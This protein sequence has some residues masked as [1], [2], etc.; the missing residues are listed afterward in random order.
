MELASRDIS[1]A[2][3]WS[4]LKFVGVVALPPALWAFVM[5][6]TG[7][8]RMFRRVLWFL[9]IEPAIVLGTL[10]VPAT[11]HLLHY[12]PP[13]GEL[14][15][16]GGSPIPIAGPLFWPHA[17]YTYALMLGATAALSVSLV[18]G[19]AVPAAGDRHDHRIRASVPRQRRLQPRRAGHH[20]RPHPV[21]VHADRGRPR[22]GAAAA[23]AARPDA[24][25]PRRGGGAD[26]RGRARP[27]RLR[28]DRGRQPRRRQAARPAASA[29]GRTAARG[30]PAVAGGANPPAPA[31]DAD[32]QRVP[33]PHRDAGLDGETDLAVS[34]TG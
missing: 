23:A 31:G 29:T 27:G 22:V 26:G 7:R 19:A 11:Y 6:Y 20:P 4:G 33:G 3:V 17:V 10:A 15:R 5:Q 12:Y 30:P 18:R 32:A 25:R 28:P 1:T 8:G 24:G 14:K 34:V 9:A 13:P 16:I 2:R 21:P